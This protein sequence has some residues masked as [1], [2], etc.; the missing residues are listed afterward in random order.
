[1]PDIPVPDVETGDPPLPPA[2]CDLGYTLID[3]ACV[4]VPL[5]PEPPAPVECAFQWCNEDGTEFVILSWVN[6]T[7]ERYER[8]P[9]T[10]GWPWCEPGTYP[11]TYKWEAPCGPD[12]CQPFVVGDSTRFFTM[13][14]LDECVPG[15]D[16]VPIPVGATPP[17][18]EQ[19]CST[20]VV[21]ETGVCEPVGTSGEIEAVQYAAESQ[22]P[23]TGSGETATIGV[24]GA[25]VLLAG[26][27]LKRI[28]S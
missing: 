25:V 28:A 22:L 8:T 17:H 18:T 4:I 13:W 20:G 23:A 10:F 26:V 1:M 27:L 6:A 14:D 24:L 19:P 11:Q 9:L 7:P 21:A 2:P 15:P 16:S 5:V 12:P 3:G